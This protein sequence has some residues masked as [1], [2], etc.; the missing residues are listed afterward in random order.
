MSSTKDPVCP[1]LFRLV[2]SKDLNCKTSIYSP[3]S[4][5]FFLSSADWAWQIR[6]SVLRLFGRAARRR[7]SVYSSQ[8]AELCQRVLHLPPAAPGAR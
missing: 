2:S 3:F 8:S 6:H 4:F 5:F 7:Q 1:I